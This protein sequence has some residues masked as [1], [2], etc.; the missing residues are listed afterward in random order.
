MSG[1]TELVPGPVPEK[2]RIEYA[3]GVFWL[4]GGTTAYATSERA[5][6]LSNYAE[7]WGAVEIRHD[8]DG[9]RYE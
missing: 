3:E 8:Y 7:Q 1:V 6:R 5:F 4:Y 9:S 2:V